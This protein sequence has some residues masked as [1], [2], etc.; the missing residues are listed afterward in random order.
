L[1]QIL[2]IQG[3]V[4]EASTLNEA[5][6]ADAHALNHT[7]SLCNALTKAS[8]LVSLM[9]CDLPAAER[10]IGML[11]NRSARHGLAMWHS[12]GNC[13]RAILLIKQGA[14]AIGLR[15]LEATLANL[16]E[17]RFSLRYTWV[18]GE[19]A[20]GLRKLGRLTEGFRSIEAA[21]ERSEQDEERWCV[22]ELLRIKA[23]LFL[24]QGG[25]SG[26]ETAERLFLQAID[27][28]HRQGALSWELRT[29]IGLSRMWSDQGRVAEAHGILSSAY[30]R[31]TEGCD[32]ADMKLAR[33]VLENI[34]KS[35]AYA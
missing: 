15:L 34:E 21:L 29:A 6:I 12:W 17:N 5:N 22:S 2:W 7:L 28:S 25:A 19:R 18:L 4:D 23:E 16:P 13:F 3:F 33:I 14:V 24:A 30:N 31:F 35:N 11:L 9:A 26:A 27:W 20:D 8:C 10:F 32:T 1:V